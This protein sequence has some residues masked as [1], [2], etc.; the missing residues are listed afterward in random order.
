M[1]RLQESGVASDCPASSGQSPLA[2]ETGIM[3]VGHVALIY[4]GLLLLAILQA[5]WYYPQ[6]PE[7]VA[8]H[9]GVSGKPD[10][11]MSR[12]SFLLVEL[13]T[14][15]IVAL[16]ML[17]M[18]AVFALGSMDIMNMPN[19]EYWTAPERKDA[20][21]NM[22]ASFALRFGILLQLFL[23]AVFI[24]AAQANLNSQPRMSGA[25]WICLAGFLGATIVLAARMIWRFMR[26]PREAA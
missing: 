8:S 18:Y 23:L 2:G 9:F 13:I 1:D 5:A 21:R 25:V 19:K 12:Q 20:T 16:L 4:L 11:W 26:I 6:L 10:G 15:F 17:A 3:S 22:L 24:L 14:S 7:T